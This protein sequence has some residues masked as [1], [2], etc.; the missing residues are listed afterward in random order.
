MQINQKLVG[1]VPN[2]ANAEFM[3]TVHSHASAVS[4]VCSENLDMSD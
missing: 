1:L 4:E 3:C 2:V